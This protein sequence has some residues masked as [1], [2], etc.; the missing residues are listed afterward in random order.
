MTTHLTR[1]N[2]KHIEGIFRRR[3]QQG[4][5]VSCFLSLARCLHL[6][7]R[8]LFRHLRD[9][10]NIVVVWVVNSE[11]EMQELNDLYGDSI[12][13]FMTDYP[14]LLREFVDKAGMEAEP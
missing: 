14:S 3:G 6:C 9:R 10:G 7:S 12:D 13:G 11:E 4:C 2:R 5:K 1:K 8:R